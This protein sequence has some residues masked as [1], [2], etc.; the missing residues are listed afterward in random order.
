MFAKPL[1]L[2]FPLGVLALA[3]WTATAG[4]KPKAADDFAEVPLSRVVAWEK[5]RLQ[6]EVMRLKVNWKAVRSS[7]VVI[8]LTAH[9][10]IGTRGAKDRQLAALRAQAMRLAGTKDEARAR[11]L[12]KKLSEKTADR[13]DPREIPAEL[14]DYLHTDE[15]GELGDLH[16]LFRLER[17]G[18]LG[19]E[20]DL[21]AWANPR[22]PLPEGGRER[23]TAQA[24]RTAVIAEATVPYFAPRPQRPGIPRGLQA[25]AVE[26]KAA[27]LDLARLSAAGKEEGELRDAVR[28]LNRS[29]EVCHGWFLA[30]GALPQPPRRKK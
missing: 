30:K 5:Q 18:G 11:E 15:L 3:G 24:L 6:R 8:A 20:R 16:F 29:C 1:L 13:A 7:A 28:T 10:R 17:S 26:M 12:V 21:R 14:K 19:I 25:W 23:L 27:A 22:E 2:T 9:H 4:P